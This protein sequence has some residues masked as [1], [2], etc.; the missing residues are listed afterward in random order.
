MSEA[1]SSIR[2]IGPAMEAAFKM[3]ESKMQTPFVIL[4][5]MKA[6]ADFWRQVTGPILLH[7]M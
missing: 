5:R 3:R 1:L 6:T 4:V 2:N 7:I